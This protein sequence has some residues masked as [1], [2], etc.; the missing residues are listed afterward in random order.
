MSLQSSS[1][2]ALLWV[3]PLKKTMPSW[4]AIFKVS[5]RPYK[6]ISIKQA[7]DVP[8][9]Q[10]ATCL[11]QG[12]RFKSIHTVKSSSPNNFLLSCI[13]VIIRTPL[14]CIGSSPSPVP[15]KTETKKSI[16]AVRDVDR[17]LHG[18]SFSG[19]FHRYLI[20][21]ATLPLLSAA[22]AELLFTWGTLV[23]SYCPLLSITA[24]YIFRSRCLIKL[25]AHSPA[26]HLR[27]ENGSFSCWIFLGLSIVVT[28]IWC[29][30][31][32]N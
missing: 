32:M 19:H 1:P 28:P 9:I 22:P 24:H 5:L 21:S 29:V 23:V 13:Y 3:G 25:R 6:N 4:G 2:P 11:L 17:D 16:N 12:I 10:C 20:H 8:I 27:T 7:K 30:F 15:I 18:S 31:W 26:T 14:P